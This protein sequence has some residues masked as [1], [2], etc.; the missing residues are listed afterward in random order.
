MNDSERQRVQAL[1]GEALAAAMAGDYDAA[2]RIVERIEQ[3]SG[4]EGVSYA[5]VVWCDTYTDHLCAGRFDL[6]SGR[7]GTRLWNRDSG[8]MSTLAAPDPEVPDR[9]RWAARLIE[10]RTRLDDE[11]W[12]AAVD[13]LNAA[14]D[15]A[16]V[17][18]CVMAT[19]E[20]VAMTINGLPRGG[21]LVRRDLVDRLDAND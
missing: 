18:E 1:A 7:A 3:E 14:D 16:F 5:M 13:G 2:A 19:L 12:A 17:G 11:A 6:I 20:C 8:A 10:A 4:G 21:G 9:V 15:A